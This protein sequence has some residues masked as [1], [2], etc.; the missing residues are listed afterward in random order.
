MIVILFSLI[1]TKATCEHITQRSS[2]H[3]WDYGPDEQYTDGPAEQHVHA[4]NQTQ[5]L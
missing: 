5:L 1:A 2:H 3:V 4:E